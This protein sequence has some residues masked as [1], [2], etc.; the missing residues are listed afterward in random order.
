MMQRAVGMQPTL[1]PE[2]PPSGTMHGVPSAARA[3]QTLL[4]H[5]APVHST[6]APEVES[7]PQGWPTWAYVMNVHL[8]V[9]PSHASPSA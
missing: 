2:A 7:Y 4:T 9:N 5:V 8:S 3:T 6:V 1:A